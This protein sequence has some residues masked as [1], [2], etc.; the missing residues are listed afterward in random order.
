MYI[1]TYVVGNK[2]LLIEIFFGKDENFKV[3]RLQQL[4]GIY[5]IVIDITA[6]GIL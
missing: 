4:I 3:V 6:I 2:N 5:T 1:P